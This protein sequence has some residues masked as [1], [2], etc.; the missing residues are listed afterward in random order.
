LNTQDLEA[1]RCRPVYD[2]VLDGEPAET[3]NMI[4]YTLDEERAVIRKLDRRLVLFVAFLYMLSFLDRSSKH[5]RIDHPQYQPTQASTTDIGN[6]R[7]A[8]LSEDLHLSSSQ[9]E[10]LLTSFYCTYIASQWMTLL[11]RV[12]PAHIYISLCVA[13]WSLV[14]S[15]QA[16]AGSFFSMFILRALLGIGEAAFLLQT[17]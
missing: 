3:A 14:A 15:L 6:A 11:H 16:L 2:S 8:G 10:W 4:S 5:E 9:C 7:I 1:I 12:V 13:S 17:G